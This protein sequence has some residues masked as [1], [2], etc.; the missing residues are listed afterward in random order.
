MTELDLTSFI[1]DVPD[2][3]SEGVLFKDVMPFLATRRG[4]ASRSIG[5]RRGRGSPTPG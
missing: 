1:R 4:S 5:W 2:F 3:P